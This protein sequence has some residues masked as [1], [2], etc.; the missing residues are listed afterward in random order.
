MSSSA[1]ASE[2]AELASSRRYCLGCR[3]ELTEA[4]P[5][6]PECGRPFDPENPRTWWRARPIWIEVPFRRCGPWFHASIAV[7]TLVWCYARS[8]P[9]EDFLAGLAAT[10]L[11]LLLGLVVLLKILVRLEIR[12]RAGGP[13]PIG[14]REWGWL[15]AP[16]LAAAGI[17]LAHTSLPLRLGLVTAQ[18]TLDRLRQ[19]LTADA[20]ATLP[21]GTMAS[22][23][24]LQKVDRTWLFL[25]DEPPR[26]QLVIEDLYSNRSTEAAADAEDPGFVFRID[27]DSQWIVNTF[28]AGQISRNPEVREEFEKARVDATSLLRP[29]SAPPKGMRVVEVML[30]EVAQGG[31]LDTG[32]WGWLPDGPDRLLGEWLEWQR[33]SGDWYSVRATDF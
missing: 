27:R 15:T 9:A 13:G 7:A 32:Y 4:A 14:A 21:P 3:H 33:V 29:G 6:C 26:D 31:F 11:F 12:L 5:R 8:V 1:A 22:W 2:S 19:E 30:F 16:L 20:T 18:G 24:R 10:G 28:D 17:A 23:Y 25:Q